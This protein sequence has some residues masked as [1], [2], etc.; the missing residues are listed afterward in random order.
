MFR[1]IL[2]ATCAVAFIALAGCK[3]EEDLKKERADLK[4]EIRQE[5]ISE[6]NSMVSSEVR[7]QLAQAIDDHKRKVQEEAARAAAAK[8]APAGKSAT[9]P[10]AP[11]STKKH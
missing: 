11:T 10:K 2:A 6:L 1:F 5:V 7:M 9:P 8:A 3:S 4:N